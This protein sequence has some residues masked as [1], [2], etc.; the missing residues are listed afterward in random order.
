MA[1]K[2][3]DPNLRR[4]ADGLLQKLAAKR[5]VGTELLDRDD[6]AGT[7]EQL[8]MAARAMTRTCAGWLM[9]CFRSSLPSGPLE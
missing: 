7:A 4:M 5:P 1:A 8:S 6:H 3:D 9:A 2:S